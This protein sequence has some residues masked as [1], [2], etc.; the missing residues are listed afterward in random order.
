M[1]HNVLLIKAIVQVDT[2]TLC[3]GKSCHT[4]THTHTH[5]YIQ[6]RTWTIIIFVIVVVIVVVVLWGGSFAQVLMEPWTVAQKTFIYIY[7]TTP[8][9]T[10]YNTSSIFKRILTGLNS[11]FS[12][13]RLVTIARWKTSV[14]STIYP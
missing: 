11:E 2:F 5:I 9:W 13:P 7:A 4:H 3:T 12:S 1:F 10:G 14:C 6:I 8:P